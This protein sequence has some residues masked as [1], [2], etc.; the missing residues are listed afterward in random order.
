[1]SCV[2]PLVT[3]GTAA[4]AATESP[5]AEEERAADAGMPA[6]AMEGR[7]TDAMLSAVPLAGSDSAERASRVLGSVAEDAALAGQ[8]GLAAQGSQRGVSA[9]MVAGTQWWQYLVEGIQE[10][11]IPFY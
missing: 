3:A 1:M 4:G 2:Q 11:V 7:H 9:M 8:S 5:A 10:F 6:D